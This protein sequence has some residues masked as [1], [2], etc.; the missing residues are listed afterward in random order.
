MM[1][2]MGGGEEI[3]LSAV[4]LCGMEIPST[5]ILDISRSLHL[6]IGYLLR[7]ECGGVGVI[8]Q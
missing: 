7:I 6:T 4:W 1:R 5:G 8:V 3:P 2:I